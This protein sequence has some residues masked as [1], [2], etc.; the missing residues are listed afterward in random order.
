MEKQ[1]KT[2]KK[3][4]FTEVQHESI[5]IH[6][7]QCS[8]KLF[9]MWPRWQSTVLLNFLE[10]YIFQDDLVKF[11]GLQRKKKKKHLQHNYIITE[12]CITNGLV[13]TACMCVYTSLT[14]KLPA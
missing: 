8:D 11:T 1:N 4:S 3:K 13:K 14:S 7:D 12:S 10:Y 2:K 6:P 5:L 9:K